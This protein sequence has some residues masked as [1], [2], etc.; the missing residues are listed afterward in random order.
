M[1]FV[2]PRQMEI[3]LRRV[4]KDHPKY[5]GVGCENHVVCSEYEDVRWLGL[6]KPRKK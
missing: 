6:I 2:D 5:D 4:R 1:G 3:A